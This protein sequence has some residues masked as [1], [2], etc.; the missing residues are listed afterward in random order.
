MLRNINKFSSVS[1]KIDGKIDLLSGIYWSRNRLL[2]TTDGRLGMRHSGE[3]GLAGKV[4]AG[5]A[6]LHRS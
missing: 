2:K 4:R 6:F 1:L 3:A 5:A